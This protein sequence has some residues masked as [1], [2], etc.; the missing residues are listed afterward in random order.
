[1]K[2]IYRISLQKEYKI[3]CDFKSYENVVLIINDFDIIICEGVHHFIGKKNPFNFSNYVCKKLYFVS[4]EYIYEQTMSKIGPLFGKRICS[5]DIDNAIMDGTIADFNLNFILANSF[6]KIYYLTHLYD[7]I[8]NFHCIVYCCADKIAEELSMSLVGL[9]YNSFYVNDDWQ[10]FDDTMLDF[11]RAK[12]AILINSNIV[13]DDININ[14]IS[15]IVFYDSWFNNNDIIPII[16][17]SLRM[18][19]YKYPSEIV[20]ILDNPT[21][22]SVIERVLNNICANSRMKN[23]NVDYTYDVNL[24]NF[25]DI[26]KYISDYRFKRTTIVDYDDV[27]DAADKQLEDDLDIFRI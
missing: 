21:Y 4:F 2:D 16:G 8:D 13:I 6:N 23:I 18:G 10:T 1:M 17:R 22:K 11:K 25:I 26:K 27:V 5:Y 9:G 12:K 14:N 20:F 3:V 7:T 15:H 24:D 19:L